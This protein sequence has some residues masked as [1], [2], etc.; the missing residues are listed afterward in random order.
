MLRYAEQ[1]D[2]DIQGAYQSGLQRKFA[3]FVKK[4]TIAAFGK[5]ACSGS[6]CCGRGTGCWRARSWGRRRRRREREIEREK[7]Y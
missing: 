1:T 7:F 3:D 4:K 2:D 6:S 5:R